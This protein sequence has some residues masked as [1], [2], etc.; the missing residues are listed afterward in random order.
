MNVR[1][2]IT[3]AHQR[4][5][6]LTNHA[7]P[8]QRRQHDN[9][10]GDHYVE[11]CADRHIGFVFV[12]DGPLRPSIPYSNR[13]VIVCAPNPAGVPVRC[14]ENNSVGVIVREG[15]INFGVVC[16]SVCNCGCVDKGGCA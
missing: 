6:Q 9:C 10:L 11:R 7:S 2:L 8:H 4:G 14:D 5:K 16:E 3:W 12:E 15:V 13:M 1:T